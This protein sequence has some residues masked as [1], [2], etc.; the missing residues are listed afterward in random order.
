MSIGWFVGEFRGCLADSIEREWKQTS[1]T[2]KEIL[3]SL[4]NNSK[5]LDCLMEH[6]SIVDGFSLQITT[7]L[8]FLLMRELQKLEHLLVQQL[9]KYHQINGDI[10]KCFKGLQAKFK[11]GIVEEKS[12]SGLSKSFIL[13]AVFELYNMTKREVEF[14]EKWVADFQAKQTT[15]EHFAI[16]FLHD[17]NVDFFKGKIEIFNA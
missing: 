5:Q 9:A 15:L 2:C 11:T 12:L 3:Y 1:S 10:L 6:K 7:R 4:Q 13:E 8:V 14:K 16:D 17:G